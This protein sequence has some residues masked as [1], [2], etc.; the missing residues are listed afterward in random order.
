MT[1]DR[2]DNNEEPFYSPNY[3]SAP[4]AR[5]R[6]PTEHV[7]TVAKG[8]RRLEGVLRFHGESYGGEFQVLRNG[9][10][11]IGRR[12]VMHDEALAVAMDGLHLLEAEG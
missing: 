6:R 8:E 9:E 7:W 4:P 11:Y 5:P 1:D 2:D 10:L 12:F 3:R